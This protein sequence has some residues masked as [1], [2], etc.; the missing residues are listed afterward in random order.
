MNNSVT[1]SLLI[2]RDKAKGEKQYQRERER[3]CRMPTQYTIDL[4][5]AC[6]NNYRDTL[7]LD[8]SLM[9]H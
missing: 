6:N 5:I 3:E 1:I 9:T 2:K 4:L 8:I 7:L